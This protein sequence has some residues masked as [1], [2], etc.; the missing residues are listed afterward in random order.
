[1]NNVPALPDQP[2]SSQPVKT[3]WHQSAGLAFGMFLL[4]LST[5]LGLIFGQLAIR[6]TAPQN[7]L[8]LN[9]RCEP[10]F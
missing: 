7:L 9:N 1:M 2:L 10:P 8:I 4:S 3:A 6:L 5:V